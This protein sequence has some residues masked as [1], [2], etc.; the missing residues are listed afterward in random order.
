MAISDCRKRKWQGNRR[1]GTFAFIRN[2]FF[3][4]VNLVYIWK[5]RLDI[6]G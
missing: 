3:L 2:S 1:L 6:I 4:R 5:E